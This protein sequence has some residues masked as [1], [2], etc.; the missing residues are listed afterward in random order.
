MRTPQTKKVTQPL[1]ARA[2][3]FAMDSKD[4]KGNVSEHLCF[5]YFHCKPCCSSCLKDHSEEV[6]LKFGKRE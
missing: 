5:L 1:E 6:I 4:N 3:V 2:L